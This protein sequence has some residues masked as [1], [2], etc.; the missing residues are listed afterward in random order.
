MTERESKV[1]DGCA[2]FFK[3][4]K[5]IQLDK[6][7]ISYSTSAIQRSDMKE[8]GAVYNRV[9]G[10][11][12]IAI[13]LLLENRATG[14]RLIVVN[15][16]LAWEGW[17]ADVKLVQV[18]ILVEQLT[19]LA[20][21]YA[22]MGPCTNKEMFKYANEDR[23]DGLP[24]PHIE[25]APSMSYSA[26]T[27]IPLL[28]CGDFNSL[29]DSGVHDLITQGSIPS[30][31]SDFGDH[32]YG[33]FTRN[34]ISHPFSLK[35]AYANIPNWSFTNWTPDFREIIDY[36]WYSTNSL[37]PIKLLGEIDPEY[38]RRVPGFPNWHFPSDHLALFAEF[39]VKSRKERKQ[40]EADFG[41]SSRR[42][43]RR[44]GS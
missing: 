40:V 24:E 37:Q 12:H 42:D 14:S 9:M 23:A 26:G 17:Q 32:K 10:K 1:V 3:N 30:S 15:T 35:S 11:D 44:D 28:I 8:G 36:V 18:G 6:Q 22:K 25:P 20:E 13:I 29:G 16:H 38:M 4:N 33:D 31:H 34:G 2:I 43:N 7:H 21:Q 5:Y 27:H 41:P 19:R 39:Q